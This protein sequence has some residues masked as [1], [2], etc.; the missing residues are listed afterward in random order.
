[1][2]DLDFQTVKAGSTGGPRPQTVRTKRRETNSPDTAGGPLAKAQTR[3]NR[4]G[5]AHI[6][7]IEPNSA[8]RHCAAQS[9]V[10]RAAKWK[11]EVEEFSS[12]WRGAQKQMSAP[13]AER[14]NCGAW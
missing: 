10:M 13:D 9:V 5:V 4:V 14:W 1:M 3:G 6:P 12:L 2:V 11:R 7:G 8:A